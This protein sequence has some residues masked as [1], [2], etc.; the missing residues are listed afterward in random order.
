MEMNDML[1]LMNIE[2]L[3]VD[4]RSEH[5]ISRDT[6][7]SKLLLLLEC[8][9]TSGPRSLPKSY[10]YLYA[11]II[12]CITSHLAPLLMINCTEFLPY[13]RFTVVILSS[14]GTYHATMTTLRTIRTR[15]YQRNLIIRRLSQFLARTCRHPLMHDIVFTTGHSPQTPETGNVRSPEASPE[16][17]KLLLSLSD[18]IRGSSASLHTAQALQVTPWHRLEGLL[19]DLHAITESYCWVNRR[20]G[21]S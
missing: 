18:Q 15:K 16:H 3:C 10:E 19:A 7:L 4:L 11:M 6:A 14:H 17:I 12:P 1:H 5:T 21:I 20:E 2:T 8:A 13:W 9:A